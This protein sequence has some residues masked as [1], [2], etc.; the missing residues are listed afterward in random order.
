MFFFLSTK[1]LPVAAGLVADL[2]HRGEA[3][4]C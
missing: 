3:R 2:P 1:F 4:I